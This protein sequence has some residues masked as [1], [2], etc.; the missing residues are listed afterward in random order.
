VHRNDGL[1]TKRLCAGRNMM[2]YSL[3]AGCF[4]FLCPAANRCFK[5]SGEIRCLEQLYPPLPLHGVMLWPISPGTLT[6][7]FWS[8]A[9]QKRQ[10]LTPLNRLMSR[11]NTV[12]VSLEFG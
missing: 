5:P 7:F 9:Q 2:M 8:H 11:E 12:N 3:Q 10:H 1:S 4:R 6:E